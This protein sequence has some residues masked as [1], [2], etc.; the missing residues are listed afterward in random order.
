MSNSALLRL[1]ALRQCNTDPNWVNADL[2]RLLYKTDLYVVA[3]EKIK[4]APGNMTPGT[5]GV[6]LDGF[7]MGVIDDVVATLRDE[8]FQFKPSRREYIPK[9][10][11]KMRPLGIPMIRAYCVSSQGAWGSGRPLPIAGRSRSPCIRQATG[12]P[13]VGTPARLRCSSAYRRGLTAT[14]VAATAAA[15][16]SA[17]RR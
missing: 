9:A 13:T 6:T 3:Y 7:S 1:E 17:A 11:G 15:P 8:S 12:V 10:N 2:Y 4:S 14:S 16:A 5:D